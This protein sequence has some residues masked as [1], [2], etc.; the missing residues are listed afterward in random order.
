MKE[1]LIYRITKAAK[2]ND[3]QYLELV[4]E[5]IV[6]SDNAKNV[7]RSKGYGWTGLDLLKTAELVPENES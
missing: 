7:L 2:D 5:I 6:M 3:K 1:E 4:A